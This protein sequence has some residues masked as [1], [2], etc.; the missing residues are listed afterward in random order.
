MTSRLSSVPDRHGVHLPPRPPRARQGPC[1]IKTQRAA[2]HPPLTSTHD[3]LLLHAAR[4]RLGR[5]PG[6]RLGAA[7]A[8][9]RLPRCPPGPAR[10]GRDEEGV[11]FGVARVSA[12]SARRAD[13][14]A[15]DAED[16]RCGVDYSGVGA[17]VDG[18]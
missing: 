6:Q 5:L 4:D 11:E 15:V 10:Q 1:R 8:F 13:G 3:V 7:H 17:R 18:A 12:V 16:A 14:P 9:R 2:P